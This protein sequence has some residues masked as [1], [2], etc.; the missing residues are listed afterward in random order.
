MLIN[1]HDCYNILFELQ[2]N[3]NDVH[4]ELKEFMHNKNYIPK[5]VINYLKEN[6]YVVIEF[7]NR[8]NNK[9]H[10]IIKEVLTCDNKPV[11]TYIKIA[12]SI[13]TQATITLEHMDAN[14]IELQNTLIENLHLAELA[15]AL[16]IYFTTGKYNTLV[17]VVNEVKSDI[18]CILDE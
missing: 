6:N 2:S 14:D 13:I 15:K 3:N 4:K 1:R 9:A 10:K 18:K 11:S 17:E 8:L 7:Y 5:C 16:N 12:T